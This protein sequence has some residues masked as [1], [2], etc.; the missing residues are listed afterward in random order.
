MSE[1]TVI[2]GKYE[3][4]KNIGC[5]SFGKV[6]KSKNILTKEEIAI[7]IQYKD[8]I[9]DSLKHEAKIYQY[10]GNIK[11]IPTLR[12][13]GTHNG[14][15]YLVTDLLELP[16]SKYNFSH[17]ELINHFISLI[18]IL[19]NIH[20]KG[21]IHRDIKPDNILIKNKEIYFIDF[22]LAKFYIKQNE[23]IEIY[24]K[25]NFVGTRKYASINVTNGLVGLPRDDIESLVFTFAEIYCKKLP[26][27]ELCKNKEDHKK[28]LPFITKLKENLDWLLEGPA[29]F[30]AIIKY[31]RRLDINTLV[32]YD[33]IINLLNNLLI[34]I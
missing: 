20:N 8:K 32:N 25:K 29:E 14:F 22:G 23:N 12:N 24:N 18:K 19:Q 10:L 13:F 1:N 26:W 28:N 7:K 16:L 31:I 21:I 2:S 34:I 17:K 15:Q 4:I 33:Y 3:I 11:G 27:A 9:I 5:G 30:I 6:F